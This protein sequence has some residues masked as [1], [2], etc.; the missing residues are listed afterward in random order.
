MNLDVVVKINGFPRFRIACFLEAAA[1][2]AMYRSMTHAQKEG[3][4]CVKSLDIKCKGRG[5]AWHTNI[6]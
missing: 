5:R 1:T 3:E 4:M 6:A 2:T